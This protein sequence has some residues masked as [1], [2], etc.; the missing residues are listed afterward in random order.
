MA[1]EVAVDQADG[2]PR[3]IGEKLT[4]VAADESTDKAKPEENAT[5]GQT[6]YF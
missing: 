2:I 3:M 4:Q 5:S 1:I 6:L